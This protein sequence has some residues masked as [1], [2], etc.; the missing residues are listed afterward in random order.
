M[1]RLF[2]TAIFLP[3]LC[4][5]LLRLMRD[6]EGRRRFILLAAAPIYYMTVQ[7]MTY[8]DYRYVQVVPY[9]VM[10]VSAV[11]ISLILGKFI[12]LVKGSPKRSGPQS[13]S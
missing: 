4:M 11:A 13:R 6:K 9:V 1:Q 10:I 7:P 12:T 2:I 8:T 5:G 3:L